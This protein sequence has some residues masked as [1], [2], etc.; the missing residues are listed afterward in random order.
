MQIGTR[1]GLGPQQ[2]AHLAKLLDFVGDPKPTRGIEVAAGDTQ[3][4]WRIASPTEGLQVDPDGLGK[5]VAVLVVNKGRAG[6]A[7]DFHAS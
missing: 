6:H 4:L 3:F 1:A 5:G 2:Q 7:F